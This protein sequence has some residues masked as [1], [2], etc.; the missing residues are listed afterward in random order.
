[1]ID[2]DFLQYDFMRN[3]LAA[4][5]AASVLCGIIGIYVILNKIVF[6]SDGIA[7][8]AFGG[9][10]LG[11]FL[12]YDPLAFGI[13]SAVLTALGIGMVSSRARV[14]EDTAI[15]VFMATG[16]ALGIMLLTLTQGYARDLYGYLFGN[17]L[18]VTVS[19]V[20]TISAFTLIILAL[21]FLLYKEFLV[22]SF[23]PIYGEAI[24]LPVQS[25]KLLLLGMVAFSVV[26]LIKI[27]GIIMV[28]ALLTIPGAISRQHMKGLPA[29]MA[30]SVFLGI[31]FVTIGLFISYL[32]DV[33]SGATIIL[34]AALTFFLSTALSR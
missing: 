4:G 13:G 3:A 31:I 23:D 5:L 22:L 12:G 10:G 33:P 7:H 8:A 24:G 26:V 25:L 28:I 14:S 34:T 19:D 1:M 15:G 11:Y 30:G 16:M 2:L 18:A 21:V 17:I 32:L 6:I 29:I 27:V 20:L 9:I